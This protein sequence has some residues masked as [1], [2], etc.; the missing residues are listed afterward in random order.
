MSL[1]KLQAR[2]IVRRELLPFVKSLEDHDILVAIGAADEAGT[3]LSYKQLGLLRLAPPS[4]LQ[5]RLKKFLL[6]RIIKK[7]PGQAD[8]RR[9]AYSLTDGTLAAYQQ[10][11]LVQVR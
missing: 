1:R 9:V 10:Y 3:P 8:G 5:R 2:S 4:T 7:L 6:S 11:I